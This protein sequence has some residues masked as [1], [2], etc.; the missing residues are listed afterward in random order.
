[1]G[2]SNLLKNKNF[3]E[4]EKQQY[5]DVIV[6]S[7]QDLLSSFDDIISVSRI[8]TDNN[9]TQMQVTNLK[10]LED[11]IMTFAKKKSEN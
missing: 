8:E 6:K 3:S 4:E 11:S 10:L 7:S 5:Y 1:M 9:P 2:F